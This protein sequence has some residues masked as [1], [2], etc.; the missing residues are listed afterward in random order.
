[1]NFRLPEFAWRW[2]WLY[3]LAL[4]AATALGTAWY[5]RRRRWY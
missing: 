2:G 4:L 3:A 5:L 1:M